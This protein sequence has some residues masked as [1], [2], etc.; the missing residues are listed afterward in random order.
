MNHANRHMVIVRAACPAW[1]VA[2]LFLQLDCV[3]AQNVIPASSGF[4]E[5][6]PSDL[7]IAISDDLVTLQAHNT[8]VQDI[9]NE[10]AL[11][12]DLVLVSYE[13]LGRQ[14]TLDLHRLPLDEVL[15][16]VLH[17]RSFLLYQPQ[18]ASP[19]AEGEEH[20]R[21]SRLWIFSKGLSD[22]AADSSDSTSVIESLEARLMSGDVSVRREA[23][24]GARTLDGDEALAPLSLALADED[25]TVR[26]K[27][28]YGLAN[29]GG[30]QAAGALAAALGDENVGIREEA[31]YALGVISGN[32]ATQ[33]LQHALHDADRGVRG[34][35]I[36]ALTD[37]GGEASV[38]ALA[39][40]MRDP[41]PS[42]REEAVEALGEIG[43][44]TAIRTLREALEDQDKVV[45]QAAQEALAELSSQEP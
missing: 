1:V 24:K 2:V 17:G 5:K 35:A 9:L 33:Y 26:V 27:A 25:K 16:Y 10:L 31:A 3:T 36:G 37:V 15:K 8:S 42:L 14:L 44:N 4:T 43:G 34:V 18:A 19:H 32:A 23:V 7:Q 13:S 21:S 6:S 38:A 30:D 22:A 39:T 41:D 28:I 20:E 29:I 45:Q 40:V 12:T 11:R